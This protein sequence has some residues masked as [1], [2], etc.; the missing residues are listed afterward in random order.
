MLR[1]QRF[2]PNEDREEKSMSV[3]SRNYYKKSYR[4]KACQNLKED[5]FQIPHNETLS[6]SKSHQKFMAKQAQKVYKASLAGKH[7]QTVQLRG[8]LPTTI[9]ERAEIVPSEIDKF[10]LYDT[11]VKKVAPK[12]HAPPP[13]QKISISRPVTKPRPTNQIFIVVKQPNGRS[14]PP[15][16]LSPIIEPRH[17]VTIQSTPK[18]QVMIPGSPNGNLT[19]P[20]IP[21]A[22]ATPAKPAKPHDS[23]SPQKAESSARQAPIK[24][25]P[26]KK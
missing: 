7:Y 6:L 21:S 17:Q 18:H 24:A 3:T 1:I 13:S 10:P 16:P 19:A 25:E 8:Q 22:A 14:R 15:P 26:E 12:R 2:K 20:V 4:Q 5:F 11:L 9:I 23:T